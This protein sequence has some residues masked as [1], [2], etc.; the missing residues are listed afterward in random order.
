MRD[1]EG[2]SKRNEGPDAAVR[3]EPAQNLHARSVS[4][5]LRFCVTYSDTNVNNSEIL[6]EV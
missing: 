3:D 1:S 2:H 5:I 6:Q 4:L